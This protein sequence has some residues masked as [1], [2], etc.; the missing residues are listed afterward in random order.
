[1]KAIEQFPAIYPDVHAQKLADFFAGRK[2]A[3]DAAKRLADE[4]ATLKTFYILCFTNRCGS[5]FLA[6]ALASEGRIRQAGEN[7]NFDA[8]QHQCDRL[9]LGSYD[10]YLAWLVRQLKGPEKVFGCKASAG[11][12]IHLYNAGVLEKV[13]DKLRFVH[14]SR[15]QPVDQGISMLIASRTRKWTST[16]AGVQADDIRYDPKELIPIIEALN[17][18]NAAFTV[19]F[20]M[21]GI[22]PTPVLYERLVADPAR[23]VRRVGRHLGLPNLKFVPEKVVYERQADLVN[24]RIRADIAEDFALADEFAKD[25]GEDAN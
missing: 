21:F 7:L 17:R 5:N 8:V 11:Q 25:D 9:G 3:P 23:V 10:E 20:D 13:K 14:I 15:R 1:M 16:D 4:L 24:L 18:Q 2:R 19:L 22:K 6:Q 12:L